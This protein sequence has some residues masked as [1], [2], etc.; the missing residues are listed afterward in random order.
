MC[1]ASRRVTSSS[2]WRARAH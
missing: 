1:V 2:N